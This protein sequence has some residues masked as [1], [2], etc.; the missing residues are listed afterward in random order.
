MSLLGLLTSTELLFSMTQEQAWLRSLL[1]VRAAQTESGSGKGTCPLPFPLSGTQQT[2]SACGEDASFHCRLASRSH[3][4]QLATKWS[5]PEESEDK[6]HYIG[7][8]HKSV[9]QVHLC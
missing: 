5:R 9:Y 7:M 3:K 1:R 8:F 4:L 6:S 2:L